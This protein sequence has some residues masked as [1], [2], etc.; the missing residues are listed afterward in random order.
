MRTANAAASLLLALFLSLT[1]ALGIA[2][3]VED[4]PTLMSR[5]DYLAGLR[6][7][8]S[9]HRISLA[10]CREGAEPA[11]R[12]VCRAKVR[13]AERVAAAALEAR[14]HG[15]IAAWER[16]QRTRVRADYSVSVA[17]R[18]APT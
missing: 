7:I 18:L 14:Y 9:E 17:R 8:Q 11:D 12:A 3:A 10:G 6:A 5:A 1:A 15:T 4:P 2:A 16:A 13:A